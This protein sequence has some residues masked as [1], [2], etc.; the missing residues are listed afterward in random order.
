MSKSSQNSSQTA[1]SVLLVRQ[2]ELRVAIPLALVVETMRPLAVDAL[3]GQPDFVLG[4]SIVR[5]AA[6]PVLD[7]GAMLASQAPGRSAR[8]VALRFDGRRAA[9]RVDEVLGL[10]ELRPGQLEALPPMLEQSASSVVEA[11]GSLDSQLLMMLQPW[12]VLSAS[13]WD[14]LSQAT[15]AS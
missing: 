5:G 4:L 12:R 2:G 14:S 13:A 7:L 1:S 10:R 15:P 3:Q 9:L 6:T 11:I 8:F